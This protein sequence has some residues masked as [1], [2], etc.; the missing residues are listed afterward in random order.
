MN[1]EEKAVFECL[2]NSENNSNWSDG[3]YDE[4]EDD[5]VFLANEGQ[6]GVAKEEEYENKDVIVIGS[7]D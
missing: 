3:D 6:V 7:K 4:L 5:F 2:E 1:A